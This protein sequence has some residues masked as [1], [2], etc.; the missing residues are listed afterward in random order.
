MHM[1]DGFVVTTGHLQVLHVWVVVKSCST[2]VMHR[3]VAHV[4]F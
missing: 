2:A 1:G 3:D 4:L